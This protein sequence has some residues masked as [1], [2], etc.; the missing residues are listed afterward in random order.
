LLQ[1]RTG[2]V[3]GRRTY[4]HVVEGRMLGPISGSV[5]NACGHVSLWA[6][7]SSRGPSSLGLDGSARAAQENDTT[8]LI[9]HNWPRTDEMINAVVNWL[10]GSACGDWLRASASHLCAHTGRVALGVVVAGLLITELKQ[11]RVALRRRVPCCPR[12]RLTD[13]STIFCG[14][15]WSGSI[16]A[17]LVEIVVRATAFRRVARSGCT[18]VGICG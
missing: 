9:W 2:R 12:L 17:K 11:V 18:L 16:S 7:L 4:Q 5:S 3:L 6:S 13:Q 8:C 14:T 1:E 10:D 15:V